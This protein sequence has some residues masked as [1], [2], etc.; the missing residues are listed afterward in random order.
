MT[1]EV[2]KRH[3]TQKGPKIEVDLPTFDTQSDTLLSLSKRAQRARQRRS[4]F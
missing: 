4:H 2:E 3:G 1:I